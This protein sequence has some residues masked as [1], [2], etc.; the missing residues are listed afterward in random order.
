METLQVA[1]LTV[2]ACNVFCGVLFIAISIPLL[3]GSVKPNYTYGFRLAKAFES[4]EN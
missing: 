4:E 2:G 3:K 1:K